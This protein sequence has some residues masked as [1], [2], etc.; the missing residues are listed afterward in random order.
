MPIGDFV[1]VG[2]KET[3]LRICLFSPRSE[4]VLNSVMDARLASLVSR[5]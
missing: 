4:V 3:K 5:V 1:R 2:R